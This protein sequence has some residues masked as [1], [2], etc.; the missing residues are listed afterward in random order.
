MAMTAP[1]TMTITMMMMTM[2]SENDNALTYLERS[3]QRETS[4]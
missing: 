2:T 1:T 4:I 3:E